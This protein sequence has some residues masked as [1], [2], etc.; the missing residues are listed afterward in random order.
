[1]DIALFLTTSNDII[2]ALNY[3]QTQLFQ[4]HDKT[5]FKF[6][7]RMPTDYGSVFT[8]EKFISFCRNNNVTV[9]YAALKYL[10]LNSLLEQTWQSL[11]YIMNTLIVHARVD[12][13]CTDCVLKAVTSIFSVVLIQTLQRHS[14]LTTTYELCNGKKPKL[15]RFRVLSCLCIVKKAI[16]YNIENP[17]QK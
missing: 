5:E 9:T 17:R 11:C 7:H 2:S 10:G 8:S 3:L 16:Y 15:E 6:T 12:E 14:K 4:I 1:M 13:S